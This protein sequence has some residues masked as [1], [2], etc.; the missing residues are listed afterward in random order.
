MY[1]PE[2]DTL[3]QLCG[4]D[5]PLAVV[6]QIF[7]DDDRFHRALLAMLHGR[8]VRLLTTNGDEVPRWR[9]GQLLSDPKCGMDH[10]LSLTLSGAK[11]A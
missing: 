6:R 3:D 10:R 8:D 2:L 4:G 9:W 7:G 1:P 11:R 5:L